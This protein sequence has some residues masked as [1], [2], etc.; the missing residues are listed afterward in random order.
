RVV[1]LQPSAPVRLRWSAHVVAAGG[2][3]E[4]A[5]IVGSF[6]PRRVQSGGRR[7]REA[8]ARRGATPARAGR[9]AQHRH[10]ACTCTQPRLV[11][12]EPTGSTDEPCLAPKKTRRVAQPVY[13]RDRAAPD[14][15][16]E[17]IGPTPF[18]VTG[19]SSPGTLFTSTPR[20]R[21]R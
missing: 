1:R 13:R 16:T 6:G 17:G 10:F 2:G 12:P 19:T 5:A 8:S 18:Q 3:A 15:D 21:R 11:A 9:R 4:G 7:L 20:E 14:R